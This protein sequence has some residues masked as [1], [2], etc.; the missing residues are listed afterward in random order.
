MH[1][2]GFWSPDKQVLPTHVFLLN[3]IGRFH[4]FASLFS[5]PLQ[6]K[7]CT[8]SFTV[9]EFFVASAECGAKRGKDPLSKVNMSLSWA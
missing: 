4:S 1:F 6:R 8:A 5:D 3:H 9:L 7:E 2:G